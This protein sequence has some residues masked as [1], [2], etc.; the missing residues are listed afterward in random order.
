MELIKWGLFLFDAA[1]WS[2]SEFDSKEICN[3]AFNGNLKTFL[4]FCL[5]TILVSRIFKETDS[6]IHK[7]E[8]HNVIVTEH[9]FVNTGLDETMF[10]DK[11]SN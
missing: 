2:F 6:I 9:T 1:I 3:T 4:V 7:D 8:K 10:L 11:Q 5:N